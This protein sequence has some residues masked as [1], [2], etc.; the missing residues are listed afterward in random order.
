[1]HALDDTARLLDLLRE[2]GP[3]AVTL[4]EL[5]VAGVRDPAR[6]LFEL[7][8]AGHAVSRVLDER[9]ECVRLAPFD[10]AR[11]VAEPRTSPRRPLLAVAALLLLALLLSSRG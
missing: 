3:E 1:M 11:L 7:E 2:A 8:L 10:G 6:A 4:A 5:E 9:V